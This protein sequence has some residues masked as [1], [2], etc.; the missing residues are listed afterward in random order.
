MEGTNLQPKEIAIKQIADERGVLSFLDLPFEVKRFYMISSNT[1]ALPR[2]NHA[3]K[4]LF[5]FLFC[6]Q[7]SMSIKL[8]DPHRK[9]SYRLSTATTGILIPPGY[10]RTLDEFGEDS[11]CIVMASEHYDETDYIRDYDEYIE[12]FERNES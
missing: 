9:Y 3:H 11:I 8:S 7:G 6:A 10:W 5:Q 4:K 1:K 12:W 2:G